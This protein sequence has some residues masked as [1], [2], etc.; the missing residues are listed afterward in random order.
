MEYVENI[1]NQE[2][3]LMSQHFGE[4][5]GTDLLVPSAKRLG[6]SW[7]KAEDS[8]GWNSRGKRLGSGSGAGMR[9]V[10]GAT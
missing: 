1:R 7:E 5:G 8:L 6:V 3:F 9:V 4:T 2:V 10:C